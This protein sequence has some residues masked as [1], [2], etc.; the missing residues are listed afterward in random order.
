[1][2]DFE[3]TIALQATQIINGASFDDCDNE[4]RYEFFGEM[5]D[6]TEKNDYINKI[7][8]SDKVNLYLSGK[9]NPH[10]VRTWGKENPHET[11]EHVRDSTKLN[12]FCVVISVKV[13]REIFFAEPTVTGICYPD[14]F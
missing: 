12:V 1:V 3:E 13:Y 7:A 14:M 10:N 11:I 4:K 9:F 8:F 6:K 5:F 2:E